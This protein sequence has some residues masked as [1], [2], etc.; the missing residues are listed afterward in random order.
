MINNNTPNKIIRYVIIA[1]C[2]PITCSNNLFCIFNLKITV[3][4]ENSVYGFTNNF[5][6]PFN[7]T[8]CF[9]IITID[10]KY[11]LAFFK[12]TFNLQL[13]A[14]YQTTRFVFPYPYTNSLVVS[15]D[16]LRK[17]FLIALSSNKSTFLLKRSSKAVFKFK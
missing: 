14:E 15:I 8:F 9:N 2:N 16:S 5:N 3:F 11:T 1:M 7:G 12:I 10:F 4:F 17:G 6:I 13:I